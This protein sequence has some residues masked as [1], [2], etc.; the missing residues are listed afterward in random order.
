MK[1]R[2]NGMYAGTQL[3]TWNEAMLQN[4][5]SALLLLGKCTLAS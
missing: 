3:Y 5:V 2:N 4:M 1:C